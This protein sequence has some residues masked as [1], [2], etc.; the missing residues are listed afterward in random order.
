M[1]ELDEYV[2]VSD[3][4]VEGWEPEDGND[5]ADAVEDV[6]SVQLRK[7]PSRV[8]RLAH[9][10]SALQGDAFVEDGGTLGECDALKVSL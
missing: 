9:L 7:S 5:A 4:N 3:G 6:N 1:S 8:V 2:S 10:R